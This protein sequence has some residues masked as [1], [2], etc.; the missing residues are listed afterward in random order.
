M[1]GAEIRCPKCGAGAADV[2]PDYDLDAA[3][4]DDA[5]V[6]VAQAWEEVTCTGGHTLCLH[7]ET[8]TPWAALPQVYDAGEG[9]R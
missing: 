5:L 1:T 7:R 8:E 4:A 6:P 9:E 3:F 2:A